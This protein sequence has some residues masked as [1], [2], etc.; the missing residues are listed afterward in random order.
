MPART[1]RKIERIMERAGEI[2]QRD[3]QGDVHQVI[4]TE[5]VQEERV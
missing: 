5:V 4:V 1:A 3:G 2:E